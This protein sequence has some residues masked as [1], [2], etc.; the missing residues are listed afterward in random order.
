MSSP[1]IRRKVNEHVHGLSSTHRRK[2]KKGVKYNI[3]DIDIYMRR[4][5]WALRLIY[6][7]DTDEDWDC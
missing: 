7:R 2:K 1:P 4:I 6:M 3:K 5:R